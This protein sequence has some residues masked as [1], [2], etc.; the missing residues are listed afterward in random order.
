MLFQ[1]AISN[2]KLLTTLFHSAISNPFLQ[3]IIY[4]YIHMHTHIL[5]LFLLLL[6]LLLLLLIFQWL[7]AIGT[8]NFALMRFLKCFYTVAFDHVYWNCVSLCFSN[9]QHVPALHQL[10]TKEQCLAWLDASSSTIADRNPPDTRLLCPFFHSWESLWEAVSVLLAYQIVFH[11]Q[12][13]HNAGNSYLSKRPAKASFEP[14]DVWDFR[15]WL[16]STCM[17]VFKFL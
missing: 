12:F 15:Q 13:G 6:L 4:I 3:N 17:Y 14:Y 2:A 16:S 10:N 7:A 9:F 11:K 1:N 8:L 5:F